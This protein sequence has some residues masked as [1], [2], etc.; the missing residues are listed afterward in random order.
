MP[1]RIFYST[2]KIRSQRCQRCKWRKIKCDENWPTCTSCAKSR[3]PCSGPPIPIDAADSDASS[4]ISLPPSPSSSSQILSYYE[5]P[6]GS[7]LIRVRLKIHSPRSYPS[8]IADRVA[9]RLVAYLEKGSLFDASLAADYLKLLPT[10]L[11]SSNALRDA[12]AL[13]CG[14]WGGFRR[15]PAT[16][17]LVDPRARVKA[18]RSL[19]KALADDNSRFASETLAAATIMERVAV[20]FDNRGDEELMAHVRGIHSLMVHRGPPNIEDELDLALAFANLGTLIKFWL[21]SGGENFYLSS[22]WLH[23]LTPVTYS[24]NTMI[25]SSHIETYK[26]M[27]RFG[28][29]PDMLHEVQDVLTSP[30][31]QPDRVN[32]LLSELELYRVVLETARQHQVDETLIAGQMTEVPD[33]ESL[34]GSKYMF[35]SPDVLNRILVYLMASIVLNRVQH[36]LCS[37]QPDFSLADLDLENRTLSESLWKCIPYICSLGPIAAT[38]YQTHMALSLE[39]GDAAERTSIIKSLRGLDSFLGKLPRDFTGLEMYLLD[40]VRSW[41]GRGVL[42]LAAEAE[43]EEVEE[44]EGGD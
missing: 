21:T 18:L 23:R 28:P 34:T 40:V 12:V 9:S 3:C 30:D 36:H 24:E 31:E 6:E 33:P 1:S 19:Q 29:W 20:L 25:P 38:L 15:A 44:Q 26:L 10:R 16:Q 8:T 39:A 22:P 37:H 2:N 13:F 42:P 5:L 35:E 32:G 27:L 4:T 41:T 43:E 7:S 17:L 11:D 14:C